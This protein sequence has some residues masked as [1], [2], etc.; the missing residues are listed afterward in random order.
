MTLSSPVS[1]RIKGAAFL[2][3][4]RWY[5]GQV[6]PERLRCIARAVPAVGDYELFPERRVLGVLASTWY[7]AELVHCLL[8]EI[9]GGLSPQDRGSL[10]MSGSQAVMDATLRGIYRTLFRWMASP[11]RYAKYAPKLWGAYYDSGRFSVTMPSNTEAVATIR[12]WA[13]HHPLICDLNKGAAKAIYD[14]MG[15][16]DTSVERTACVAN[17]DP[18]CRFVTRWKSA[19]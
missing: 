3:F 12:D 7:P 17:G 9:A 6:G 11:Q 18:E 14:A 15:C 4:L 13:T 2:E 1:G 19:R 10:A 5:E 16:A 8:D